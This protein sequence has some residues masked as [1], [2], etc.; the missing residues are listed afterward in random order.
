MF[1]EED[2][3]G[4]SVVAGLVPATVRNLIF[5][6]RRVQNDEKQYYTRHQRVS[7]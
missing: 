3:S 6:K 1:V 4:I 7:Y 5:P 2:V